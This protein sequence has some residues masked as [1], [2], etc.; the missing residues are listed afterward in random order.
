[1]FVPITSAPTC[2][3]TVD[4]RF[5]LIAEDAVLSGRPGWRPALPDE[6]PGEL[7]PEAEG[8]PHG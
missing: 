3:V 2:N 5:E 7:T 1:M 6:T 8:D 4:V